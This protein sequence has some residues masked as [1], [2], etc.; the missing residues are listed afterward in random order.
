MSH[1]LESLNAR[2][3]PDGLLH[4]DVVWFQYSWLDQDL[5]VDPRV[6]PSILLH[7]DNSGHNVT[8]SLFTG[9]LAGCRVGEGEPGRVGPGARADQRVLAGDTVPVSTSRIALEGE[10]GCHL[11]ECHW[12][13]AASGTLS[14]RLGAGVASGQSAQERGLTPHLRLFSRNRELCHALGPDGLD[15]G[16]ELPEGRPLQQLLYRTCGGTGCAA[17]AG[18]STD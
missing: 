4:G 10:Q 15:G 2:R 17:Q 18:S 16:Q 7:V 14:G 12:S 5:L 13:A 8:A 1:L 3:Q 6:V 11:T 9:V